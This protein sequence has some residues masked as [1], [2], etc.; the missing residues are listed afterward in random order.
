MLVKDISVTETVLLMFI[1]SIKTNMV[2]G[3]YNA[4]PVTLNSNLLS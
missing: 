4:S 3:C 1:C 2:S